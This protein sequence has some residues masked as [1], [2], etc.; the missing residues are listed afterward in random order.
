VGGFFVLSV[1]R[2][3]DEGREDPVADFDEFVEHTEAEEVGRGPVY[4]EAPERRLSLPEGRKRIATFRPI[5]GAGAA[6]HRGEPAA[7]TGRLKPAATFRPI[8]GTRAPRV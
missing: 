7:A 5:P 6:A 2:Q 1:L 4:R 8:P 3:K